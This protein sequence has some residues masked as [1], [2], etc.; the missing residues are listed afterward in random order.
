[1]RS[2][3]L[4]GFLFLAVAVLTGCA[5]TWVVEPVSGTDVWYGGGELVAD[6][7]G[8]MRMVVG[9]QGKTSGTLSFYTEFR[10]DG[11]DAV[12]LDPA[13]FCLVY[14]NSIEMDRGVQ[15]LR[16]LL[17]DPASH[18][19]IAQEPNSTRFW[20][21]TVRAKPLRHL[22]LIDRVAGQA[23][24]AD[25][26]V[27]DKGPSPAADYLRKVTL[28]PGETVGGALRFKDRGK[29]RGILLIMPVGERTLSAR[30][31]RQDGRAIQLP[32]PQT[33]PLGL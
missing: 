14:G 21:P 24:A 30:F 20:G 26:V 23:P 11:P 17:R 13:E 25:L 12:T 28:Q 2:S 32:D 15:D 18:G 33:E 1:M 31:L 16:E 6:E 5:R 9:Y 10:N 8:A 27:P 29:G 4:F 22:G 7:A 3:F 19:V